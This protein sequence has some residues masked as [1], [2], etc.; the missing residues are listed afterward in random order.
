MY[1][2]TLIN[3]L[4]TDVPGTARDGGT[5]PGGVTFRNH[6]FVGAQS[7]RRAPRSPIRATRTYDHHLYA[8]LAGIPAR[9]ARPVRADPRFAA[10][11]DMRL[12]IGSPALGAGIPV[13]RGGDRDLYGHPVPD[14]PNSGAYQEHGV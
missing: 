2:S 14:P 13:P 4:I 9:R 6:I 1:D 8:R 10:P 11:G 12:R 3:T 5:G 7:P